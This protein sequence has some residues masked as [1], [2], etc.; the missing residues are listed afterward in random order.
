MKN[1]H[2][3][4]LDAYMP[5]TLCLRLSDAFKAA[6]VEIAESRGDFI[7]HGL[8]IRRK[9]EEAGFDLYLRNGFEP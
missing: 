8:I 7:D 4:P 5:N 2:D 1:W 3:E 9:L 6:N